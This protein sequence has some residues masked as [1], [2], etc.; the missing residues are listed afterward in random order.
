[1]NMFI[2]L[3]A[4]SKRAFTLMEMII[5]TLIVVLLFYFAYNIYLQT[6]RAVTQKIDRQLIYEQQAWLFQE[7]SEDLDASL[8][9]KTFLPGYDRIRLTPDERL[10]FL[11]SRT[12]DPEKA[13]P[14]DDG[15]YYVEYRLFEGR[16]ERQLRPVHFQP[17]EQDLRNYDYLN[18]SN[19]TD[20][21]RNGAQ[22]TQM[23]IMLNGLKSLPPGPLNEIALV[24]DYFD[25]QEKQRYLH[26]LKG[27]NL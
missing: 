14:L 26:K 3:K 19:L 25:G 20:H 11:I 22:V 17:T 7:L 2:P 4:I 16:V 6:H 13:H 18:R 9:N 10:A 21:L 12:V 23:Q 24:I 15:L 5:V 8:I 1:M 27:P